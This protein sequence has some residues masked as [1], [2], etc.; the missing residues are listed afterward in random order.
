MQ[1]FSTH[2]GPNGKREKF[3][4]HLYILIW[5]QNIYIFEPSRCIHQILHETK[6]YIQHI[7]VGGYNITVLYFSPPSFFC[8]KF[9]LGCDQVLHIV[10]IWLFFFNTTVRLASAAEGK[11][12]Y[13]AFGPVIMAFGPSLW[14]FLIHQIC[15]TNNPKLTA[16]LNSASQP[17]SNDNTNSDAVHLS[18][19][20]EPK[21]DHQFRFCS[22]LVHSVLHNFKLFQG[23]S[24]QSST[25]NMVRFFSA[26]SQIGLIK[27]LLTE[28][29]F[30]PW[31]KCVPRVRWHISIL[32]KKDV[33][34]IHPTIT[35]RL[36]LS[37]IFWHTGL[38]KRSSVCITFD[39][40]RRNQV[41]IGL[42]RGNAIYVIPKINQGI[43]IQ[44]QMGL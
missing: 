25:C 3:Y 11:I 13:L 39:I 10:Q 9:K 27:S 20:W 30:T 5:K 31:K 43:K 8:K 28:S 12:T 38:I 44:G 32:R 40:P 7:W 22:T 29:K 21:L 18:V 37:L 19:K 2:H 17:V 15:L 4:F 24:Q 14:L 35:L 34:S 6:W 1:I 41:R 36:D 26:V 23:H 16:E 42:L 33:L